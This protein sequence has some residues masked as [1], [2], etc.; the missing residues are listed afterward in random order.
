MVEVEG[1]A[2]VVMEGKTTTGKP[3]QV[4]HWQRGHGGDGDVGYGGGNHNR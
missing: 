1:A 2:V 4:N 3:H